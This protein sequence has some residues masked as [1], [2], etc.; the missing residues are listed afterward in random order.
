MSVITVSRG[1]FSGGKMIAERVAE[2]LEY[3][4][5]DRDVIVEKAAAFGVSQDVLRDA[6]EKPPTFL[7]R[8]QHKKYQYVTLIQAALTEEVKTGRTVYHGNAGHL[9]LR[10]GGPVFR[11]RIIAPLEFRITMARERLHFDRDEAIEHIYKMDQARQ[12][13]TQY[14]YGVDWRDP[15]LYDLVINLENMTV[16]D[17]SEAIIHLVKRQRCFEFDDRCREMMED[18]ALA[19]RVKADLALNDATSHLE[20]EVMA[21]HRCVFISGKLPGT[22]LINDVERIALQVPGVEKV[23]LSGVLTPTQA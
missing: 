1:S 15:S 10:G 7:E 21:K 22:G 3:R 13:W 5:V 16:E 9:L 4:C 19:S 23:D 17:A 11:T 6:L 20:F 12:K 2:S 14:L 18:L 8:F